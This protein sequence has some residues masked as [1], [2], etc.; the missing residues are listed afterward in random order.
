MKGGFPFRR[1]WRAAGVCAILNDASSIKHTTNEAECIKGAISLTKQTKILSFDEAK[2]AASVPRRS[3]NTVKAAQGRVCSYNRFAQ[4]LSPSRSARYA[5]R[6]DAARIRSSDAART[7]SSADGASGY[8]SS[9]ARSRSMAKSYG[10][11]MVCEPEPIVEKAQERKQRQGQVQKRERERPSWLAQFKKNRA[12]HKADRAFNKRYGGNGENGAGAYQGG[13]AAQSEPRAAVYRGEMG[14]THRRASRMQA[15]ASA[16]P[17]KKRTAFSESPL[18]KSPKLTAS[19]A[20]VA[21]LV[22]ACVYLYPTAR[23]YYLSVRECDRLQA[24]YAAVEQRNE[25]I[26]S[27][28]DAL[29]TSEGVEDRARKELGWA[30]VGEH[31]ATVRGLDGVED[32]S[33]FTA[34]IV[35]GSTQVPETWYSVW[36]DPFFG[37][38]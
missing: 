9:S 28:V 32:E 33:T 30:K 22:L 20:V 16:N 14:A 7:G 38:E 37:V 21:C 31:A 26:Q 18:L 24:E 13:S 25:A 5:E 29:G 12:K 34:S 8:R 19:I 17:S 23:Q 2:R 11:P 3:S 36:L 27:E 15:T 10:N 4:S 35:A 1:R 6:S